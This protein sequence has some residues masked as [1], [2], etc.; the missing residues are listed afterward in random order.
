MLGVFALPTRLVLHDQLASCM[1]RIGVA[2][3]GDARRATAK[4]D[5]LHR[6][7]TAWRSCGRE[8]GGENRRTVRDVCVCEREM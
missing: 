2:E 4:K 6:N 5:P 1:A 7:G 3:R 8:P